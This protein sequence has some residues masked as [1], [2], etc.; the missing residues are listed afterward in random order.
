MRLTF[1]VHETC[2]RRFLGGPGLKM[3]PLGL[4]I[5]LEHFSGF[6]GLGTV[7]LLPPKWIKPTETLFFIQKVSS[8]TILYSYFIV[9]KANLENSIF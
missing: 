7:Q 4:W 8:Y 5:V 6:Q 1:L 9:F 3:T 2:G